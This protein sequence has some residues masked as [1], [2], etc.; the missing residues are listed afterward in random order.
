[1]VLEAVSKLQSVNPEYFPGKLKHSSHSSRM[2]GLCNATPVRKSPSLQH[3]C[4]SGISSRYCCPADFDPSAQSRTACRIFALSWVGKHPTDLFVLKIMLRGIFILLA[5]PRRALQTV[6]PQLL[7]LIILS[8]GRSSQS[9][10][11]IFASRWESYR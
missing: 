2:A 1:M 10:V 5:M 9:W 11:S 7:G 4:T 6:S 8:G 3:S